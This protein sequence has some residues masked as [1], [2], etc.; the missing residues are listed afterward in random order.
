MVTPHYTSVIY[1]LRSRAT[2]TL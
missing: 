2:T 1:K